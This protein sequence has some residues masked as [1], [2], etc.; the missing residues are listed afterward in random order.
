MTENSELKAQNQK[1]QDEVCEDIK[2][3]RGT[4]ANEKKTQ[5]YF[6]LLTF[7]LNF[8]NINIK[9][10]FRNVSTL[11]IVQVHCLIISVLAFY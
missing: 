3:I 1:Y 7:M 9:Y 5:M 6:I 10:N 11:I 8:R 4:Y 2:Q